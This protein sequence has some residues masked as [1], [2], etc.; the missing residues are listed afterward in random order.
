MIDGE[1]AIQ[2]NNVLEGLSKLTFLSTQKD[3]FAKHHGGTCQWLLRSEEFQR[4][5]SENQS[6]TLWCYGDRKKLWLLSYLGMIPL[7]LT[8]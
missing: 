1:A 4:W 3:K 2:R 5:F 6:S 8:F 7:S